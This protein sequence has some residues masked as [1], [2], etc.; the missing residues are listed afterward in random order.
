MRLLRLIALV[1]LTGISAARAE[2]SERNFWPIVVEQTV[3]APDG[4]RAVEA[5]QAVGPL[6]FEE[7]L[8]GGGSAGGLRPIY[9]WQEDPAGQTAE[10]DILYPLLTHRIDRNSRRWSLFE[11]VNFGVSTGET[12][13]GARQF[14]V[15]PFYFSRQT[16]DPATSY[17]AVFPLH[18]TML[19]RF[20]Y[21]RISWTLFPLYARFERA[22]AVKTNVPWPFVR[23][24]SGDGNRGFALWP[25]FG[26]QAKPGVYHDRFYLWPLIYHNESRLGTP[27]PTVNLGVLPFYASEAGAGVRSETF[28]WPFFGYTHRTA[29]YRYDETRWLWPFLV[30]GRGDNRRVNRWGPIYTHSN[31]KGDDKRWLLWPLFRQERW[32][33][34]GLVQTKTQLLYFLYWSL[35]QRSAARPALAPARKTHVWPL[36]SYWDNGAGR[37]QLQLLSPFEVFF[38]GNGSV[39]RDYTPLLA[40]YRYERRSADEVRVSLLW[41]AITWRRS[42]GRREFHLGPL[43]HIASGPDRR[44]VTL[45]AGLIG[46]RR[47]PGSTAWKWF[48]F[49][50][51]RKTDKT[52]LAAASP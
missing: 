45:G 32:T 50:F 11:L 19:G 12:A 52:T 26:W 2:L 16:G 43:L 47:S 14:D 23:I 22:G 34:T 29:P 33:E 30:Q 9:V 1:G 36:F 41:S 7:K 5:W 13:A 21:D 17:R 10:T 49:D 44:R 8:E 20:G 24:V 28:L 40:L 48:L 39:R 46:L 31:I 3:A 27:V 37:R 18:G 6:F 25:L 51:S 35:E 42:A 4:G 15:W 38:S